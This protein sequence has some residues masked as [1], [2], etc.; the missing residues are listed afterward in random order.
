MP[1]AP[2]PAQR[3]RVYST[4]E[5]ETIDEVLADKHLAQDAA[6]DGKTIERVDVVPL[7]PFEKRDILPRWLNVFHVT[8]RESVDRDE[9]LLREG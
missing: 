3:L 8:T 5:Q 9:V 6:P 7:P 1:G 4:Y 2:P